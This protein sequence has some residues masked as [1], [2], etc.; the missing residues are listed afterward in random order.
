MRKCLDFAPIKVMNQQRVLNSMK[1]KFSCKNG[2]T[3]RSF[4]LHALIE[5]FNLEK[6]KLT[7]KI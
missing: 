7:W 5:W 2:D 6:G 1:R 4:R 3:L